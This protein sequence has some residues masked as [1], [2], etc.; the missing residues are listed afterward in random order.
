MKTKT[1]KKVKLDTCPR[2]DGEGTVR[3]VRALNMPTWLRAG[4]RI[5]P[6]VGELAAEECGDCGG[7]GVVRAKGGAP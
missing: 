6:V 7:L 1:P 5:L 4:N 2:C 3:R